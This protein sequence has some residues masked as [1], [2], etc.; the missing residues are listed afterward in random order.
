MA[1][2]PGWPPQFSDSLNNAGFP[3]LLVSGDGDVSTFL[4]I[5]GVTYVDGTMKRLLPPWATGL[6]RPW[7]TSITSRLRTVT[8]TRQ[9][10]PGRM[11]RRHANGRI[12]LSSP[13]THW[14]SGSRCSFPILEVVILA[15]AT[16]IWLRCTMT[17]SG[18]KKSSPSIGR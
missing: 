2:I 18:A 16:T 6:L 5:D 4:E 9:S 13:S 10:L 8:P 17:L 11:C 3:F 14:F 7:K 1:N 15:S 12:R